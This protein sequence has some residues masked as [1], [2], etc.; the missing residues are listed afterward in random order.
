MAGWWNWLLGRSD[1]DAHDRPETQR[2]DEEAVRNLLSDCCQSRVTAMVTWPAL[3]QIRWFYFEAI[4]GDGLV[5]RTVPASAPIKA[6]PASS[7]SVTFMVNACVVVFATTEKR[8]ADDLHD[9]RSVLLE[10]PAQVSM[11]GR[12]IFRVPVPPTFQDLVVRCSRQDRPL[13][14]ASVVDISAAGIQLAFTY[15]DD[16]LLEVDDAVSVDLRLGSHVARVE[17][18]VRRSVRGPDDVRFGILFCNALN[19]F[20]AAADQDL[21]AIVRALERTW[22]TERMR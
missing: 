9:E 5:L 12:R 22:L 15:A 20:A 1:D 13:P 6:R 4:T 3:N 16:P 2:R 11:E 21:N 14:G 10:I 7:C 18:L 17:G 8:R 19:G